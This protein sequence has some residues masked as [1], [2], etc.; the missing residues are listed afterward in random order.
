MNDSFQ[1]SFGTLAVLD[2]TGERQP[3]SFLDKDC[4]IHGELK[5]VIGNRSLPY[6]GYFG[7]DDVC[8]STWICELDAVAEAFRNSDTASYLFDE[9]EQSQPAFLFEKE[10]KTGFLSIVDSPLSDTEGDPDWQRV[11]F[12]SDD[13]LIRYENFRTDF[14]NELRHAAPDGY[15]EWLQSL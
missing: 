8:F 5:I 3:L 14:I 4:H 15:K 2:G 10:G 6:L 12:N 13:F 1:I 7:P 11:E 9:G